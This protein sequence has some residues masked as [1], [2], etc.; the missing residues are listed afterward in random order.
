MA[1]RGV[2]QVAGT[3]TSG[4]YPGNETRST[5]GGT[6]MGSSAPDGT[7]GNPPGTM[8][9]RAVDKVAGT[10]VSGAHPENEDGTPN[11]PPGTAGERA[12]DRNLG[13]NTTGTKPRSP[14]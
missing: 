14:L 13:T 11:N 10:N 6:G 3:N 4:A 8:A 1:S 9:S 2:D 5:T 7:P 12:A